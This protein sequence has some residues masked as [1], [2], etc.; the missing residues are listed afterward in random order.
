MVL[1]FL[2]TLAN[3]FWVKYG[4][5]FEEYSFQQNCCFGLRVNSRHCGHLRDRDLVSV[6]AKAGNWDYLSSN[7]SFKM[8]WE[9]PGRRTAMEG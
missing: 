9:D 3:W 6:I 1:R 4:Q 8:A 5:V 2:L 7:I